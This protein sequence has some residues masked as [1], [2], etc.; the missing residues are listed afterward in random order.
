MLSDR[1]LLPFRR[2]DTPETALQEDLGIFFFRKLPIQTDTGEVEGFKV[3]KTSLE[4]VELACQAHH[5][6]TA[7]FERYLRQGLGEAPSDWPNQSPASSGILCRSNAQL[8]LAGRRI[9]FWE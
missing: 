8:A 6:S 5:F 9:R 7:E 3:V 4:L 2:G 1:S